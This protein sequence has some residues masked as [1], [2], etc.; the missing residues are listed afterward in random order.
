MNILKSCNLCGRNCNINRYNQ[1]GICGA[2][3]K[4][5]V[6]RCALHYYEEPCIS[7]KNGS[8]AIFFSNCNLKCIFCQ[9]KKISTNGYG[10]EISIKRF[11]EIC[12]E[13]QSI[14]AH[15]INLVTPTMYVPHI[16]KGIKKA[17]K[18][19]LIIPIIYNTSSYENIETIK[20]LKNTVD[21]YLP[22]LKYYNDNY[23]LKY[24]HINNYFTTATNAIDEMYKQVGKV[25]IDNNDIIIKGVIVRIL[26]LPGLKEDAKKL[27]SYLYEKYKDNIF[28]SIMNQYTPLYN[29]KTFTN[30]NNKVTDEEYDEVVNYA[31]DLGVKNGYIQEGDTQSVEFIPNFDKTGIK[32]ITSY[33]K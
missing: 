9:N 18:N 2:N 30:L 8:G 7:G 32:K 6:A 12:L 27:I 5:K 29:F 17:K 16:I 24:S 3:H 25:K 10:L 19:G 4:L 13:L 11:S 31:C 22:D 23:A 15:N 28:I 21:V 1:R 33:V 14:G 20:L 26:L